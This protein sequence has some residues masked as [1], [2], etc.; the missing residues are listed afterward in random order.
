MKILY[1]LFLFNFLFS[2]NQQI[3]ST[4]QMMDQVMV[5]DPST[6]QIEQS[7]STEFGDSQLQDCM[8]YESQMDCNLVSNCE[9]MMGMC[10]DF[11]G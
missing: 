7:I 2:T 9:W 4:I 1:I 3:Y 11:R 10:M 5:I 6:L 8:D